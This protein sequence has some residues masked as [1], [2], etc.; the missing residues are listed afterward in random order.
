[1]YDSSFTWQV[2]GEKKAPKSIVICTN[3][4]SK[5]VQFDNFLFRHERRFI[6]MF[7]PN[8]TIRFGIALKN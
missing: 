6:C 4:I 2:F 1:M 8:C 7:R 3:F 5:E